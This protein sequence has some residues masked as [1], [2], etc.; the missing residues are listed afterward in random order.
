MAN[1]KSIHLEEWLLSG[2]ERKLIELNVQSLEGDEAIIDLLYA[3]PQSERRNDGRLRNKYL[4]QYSHTRFGGWWVSGLDPHNNWQSMEWG[5][6]K[7]DQPRREWDKQKQ[8]H[9]EKFVKYE[10][11]AKVTNRVTYL[12][13]PLHVWEKIARRYNVPMPENVVVN[14]ERE[15]LGFWA[16]VVDNPKIPVILTEGEKKAGCLLSLGFVALALPG[17]WGGRVGEKELEKLHPDLI[18]LAQKKRVFIIL[19]DYETKL[20]TKRSIFQATRRTGQRLINQGCYC[21][22]ALLP[23]EEKGVDDWVVALKKKAANAVEALIADR[24]TLKEYQQSFFINRSRGL[25]KYKPSVVVNARFIS[26]AI[27]LPSSGLV[28][29]LSSMGSGKTELLNKYR[30]LYPDKRFLNNGHRVNLLKNLAKRLNTQMYTAL[31]NGDLVR[32]NALSITVDSLYKMAHNVQEYDCLFIDEAC[33]YLV[34]LLHSK[35]CRRNRAEILEVL[36]YLVY[37]SK[38][39]I[40]ADAHLNDL[41]IDFFRKMRPRGEEPIIFENRWKSPGRDVYWYEGNNSNDLI[42]QLHRKILEGKKIFLVSDSKKF[43]KKVEHSLSEISLQAQNQLKI[44]AIHGDNSG[45]P[46]N[47]DFIENINVAIKTID[48]L[49]ASPSIGTGVDMSTMHFDEIL[50]VFHGVSQSAEECVQQLWRYRPNV[51]MHVWVA[52]HPPF[53]YGL[54]HWRKIKQQILQK[55]ELTAFLIRVDRKTGARGAEKDWALDANC[56]IQA[57]RNFSINNLRADLRSLLSEMECKIIPVADGGNESAK[58]L[59]KIVSQKIDEEYCNSVTNANCIDGRTYD[60]RQRQ[61]YLKPEEVLECE[62]FRIKQAY[63]MAVT[64]ELVKKDDGGKLIKKIIQLEA[65]LAE[66]VTEVNEQGEE[67]KFPPDLVAQRDRSERERMAICTDWHNYSASWRMRSRLGLR[68]ILLYMFGGG[69]LTGCEDMVQELGDFSK[70]YAVHIK[71]ILN[72]TI[73][74]NKSGMWAL[75]SF[76]NQIGLSTDFKRL[77]PRDRRVKY[78]FL[79]SD[80]LAF[81]Q[82]VL[83]YRQKKRDEK[84]LKLQEQKERSQAHA[85][86]IQT[87]YGTED[88]L[89]VSPP[90]NNIME[91]FLEEGEDTNKNKFSVP[92]KIKAFTQL[93]KEAFDFGIETIKELIKPLGSDEIKSVIFELEKDNPFLFYRLVKLAPELGIT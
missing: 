38:L 60:I 4:K 51:P 78:Y 16:W 19:F 7:P 68:E 27:Q 65:I 92:Q 39:V 42:A 13:I 71:A 74:E 12:R 91:N 69:R 55:N 5:R 48:I 14:S 63:G 75:G 21:D 81:A 52:P 43:I 3:L 61:E 45:S 49:L 89:S 17:I 40:L 44:W 32:A 54:T 24:L 66:P 58:N 50:G 84:E 8:K 9:T 41:T 90:P 23:G 57:Q 35:T 64:P 85:A 77:G 11:P 34:H 22:V 18:P 25:K 83:E 1:I 33:Q 67:F 37:N 47:V 93:I 62:K 20:K 72:L 70:Q 80:D 73:P 88:N 28:G 6:F 59:M 29:L 10:S 86:R 26:D 53:G 36:E 31:G 76:L 79:N 2:V 56:K 30:N 46:E 82:Q 87:I 15:A